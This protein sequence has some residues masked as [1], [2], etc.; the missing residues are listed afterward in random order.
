MIDY[1]TRTQAGGAL[2]FDYSENEVTDYLAQLC[3]Q[4]KLM[5]TEG[6]IYNI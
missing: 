3:A 6:W 4:N 2:T 5:R 1:V